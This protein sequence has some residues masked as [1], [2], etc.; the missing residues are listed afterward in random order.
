MKQL[1]IKSIVV[2]LAIVALIM[3][4]G[5]MPNAS[6]F[7]FSVAKI[8]GCALLL[9]AARIWDKNIPEEEV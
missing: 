2:V 8:G 9:A 3:L 4:V 5:D 1:V 6:A 7:I